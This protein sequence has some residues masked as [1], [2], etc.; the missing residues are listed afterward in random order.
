M[1]DKGS[2]K[3][4]A[5]FC[6]ISLEGRWLGAITLLYGKFSSCPLSLEGRGLGRG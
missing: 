5:S 1:P 2:V 6:P 3:N 4:V